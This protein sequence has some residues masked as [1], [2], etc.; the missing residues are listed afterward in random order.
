MLH[1]LYKIVL[2]IIIFTLKT[3]NGE[4]KTFLIVFMPNILFTHKICIH[5]NP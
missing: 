4:A 2:S 5:T 1:L 3:I